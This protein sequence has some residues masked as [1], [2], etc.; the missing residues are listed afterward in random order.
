[1]SRAVHA[2]TVALLSGSLWRSYHYQMQSSDQQPDSDQAAEK[3]SSDSPQN[4]FSLHR[5]SAAFARLTGAQEP[6]SATPD[7]AES[8]DEVENSRSTHTALPEVVSPRMIVEGMLFVG[9]NEGSPLTSRQ[10]AAGI[11]D[12]TPKEVDAIIEELNLSYREHGTAYQVVSEGAGYRMQLCP[13]YDAL[14]QRFSGKVREAKLTPSAIE[15]L[16]VVAYRQPITADEVGK[17]RGSRSGSIL[18]QLV[19]RGLLN[20]ERNEDSPRKPSYHTTERF[21]QLFRIDSPKELPRSEELDD[22]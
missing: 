4:R 21:N 3:Q 7:I 20:L 19:R 13:K 22:S 6:D 9:N 8:L 2:S 12:V 5:L 15:V 17:L 14:R 11:R 18:N 10:L 16:S 1:M